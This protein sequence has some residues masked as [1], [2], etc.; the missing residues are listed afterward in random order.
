MGKK[1]RK[2]KKVSTT[3]KPLV[4]VCT[5]TYNRRRFIPFLIKCFESQ[6]Y[7]KE[8]MEWIVV[9]DGT[10]SVED[11]FTDPNLKEDIKK[12]IKYFRVEEKMKLGRKRNYMH[13]KTK[14]EIL[15]YMDD[16]D[17]YPPE[18]VNNAV[19][20]LRGQPM[21]L[22]GGSS[23][24]HIYF[25]HLDK[26]YRFGPYGPRHATAGTFAFKRKLLKETK[27]DDDAEM[28]EEKQFLKNYTVPF[29]QLDTMKSILVFAHDANT[30]DKKK[31][32]L[33]PHPKFVGETNMRPEVFIK[34]K[35]MREFYMK[36]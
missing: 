23:C 27:Y 14:G 30:F 3:G 19:N 13:E 22:A 28:A 33:N 7:P 8:L 36:Q 10:D 20:R 31:L 2:K 5:P 26:I 12:C 18:R 24:I 1:N 17:F 9:D 21:A 32:L 6:T 11:L 15:V 35:T 4:S 25:K 34:D 16:D 29:V